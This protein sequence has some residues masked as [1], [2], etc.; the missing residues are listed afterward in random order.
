MSLPALIRP[1]QFPGADFVEKWHAC[2]DT[3][4]HIFET[5]IANAGLRFQGRPVRCR[6]HP[7]HEGKH[8]SFWHLIQEGPVE[9]N[10][11]PDLERCARIRW[12]P[13]VLANANNQNIIRWWENQ[14][15]S[16]HGSKTHVPLWL[17]SEQYAVILEKRADFY[18]LLTSYCLTPHRTAT[19]EKEWSAWC[20]AKKPQAPEKAEAAS[21]A[22]SGTPS[23]RG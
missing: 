9:Q 12:V 7:P 8:M 18:L 19:F 15:T 4:Y 6:Y 2:L 10:R 20:A 1:E 13:W 14:R 21:K 23:T 22:A 11:T 16:Q 17:F 5:E 3:I